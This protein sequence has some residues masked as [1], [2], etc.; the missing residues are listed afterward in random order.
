MSIEEGTGMDRIIEYEEKIARF[1]NN[2]SKY[3]Q[4]VV[5][6]QEALGDRG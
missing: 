3:S 1:R 2:I 4:N 5:Q 6:Y